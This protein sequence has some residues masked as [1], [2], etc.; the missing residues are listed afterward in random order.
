MTGF[1]FGSKGKPQPLTITPDL[2]AVGNNGMALRYNGTAWSTTTLGNTNHHRAIWG[3]SASNIYV[4]GWHGM[5]MRY[6]GT[7]WNVITPGV[8]Y[9]LQDIWGTGTN[10]I[11][12][13]GG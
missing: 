5:I 3:T 13:A 2:W 11:Y 10:N 7:K 1:P 9:I 8:T 12:A 4:V 6:N